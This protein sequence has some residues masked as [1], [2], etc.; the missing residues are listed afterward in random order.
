VDSELARVLSG[1]RANPWAPRQP[2]L[3]FSARHVTAGQWIL[4]VSRRR[5][6]KPPTPVNGNPF[7]DVNAKFP[8]QPRPRALI[9]KSPSA[10]TAIT[11]TAATSK[12]TDG[13]SRR[14]FVSREGTSLSLF[15]Q[16]SSGLC[17]IAFFYF[18]VEKTNFLVPKLR[19][20]PRSGLVAR[21]R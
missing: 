18:I 16:A 4:S 21:E 10:A 8:I 9:I 11:A 13:E 5:W 17:R 15:F 14:A 20:L 12:C 7:G 19:A 2:T 6:R 3:S 1:H